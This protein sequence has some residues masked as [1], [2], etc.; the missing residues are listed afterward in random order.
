MKNFKLSIA[1]IMAMSTFA[2]AGG[3]IAPVVE[4]VVEVQAPSTGGFYIGGAI[5]LTNS[6]ATYSETYG[7][8]NDGYT[9]WHETIEDDSYAFMLQAGYEFNEYIAIEGRYWDSLG[10]TNTFSGA[11]AE[12]GIVLGSGSDGYGDFSAWGIYVKPMYPVTE[13]LD[14]YALLGYG[15]TSLKGDGLDILDEDGFQWG[16]GASYSLSEN[17]SF[18]VDYVQLA[19]G[20]DET[21]YSYTDGIWFDEG[22]TDSSIYTINI[23]LT[24]K[25]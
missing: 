16:L 17:T 9:S 24:Y 22:K 8:V 13:S 18:F 11:Y 2:V 1:T 25:F 19:D 23:G 12:D 14:V 7:W 15:N 21:V 5:G 4:P 10:D 6:E 3:D 20:V